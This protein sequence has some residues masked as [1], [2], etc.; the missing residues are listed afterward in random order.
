M[1]LETLYDEQN[2]QE[3]LAAV[4]SRFCP[5]CGTAIVQNTR[6]RKKVFCSESCRLKWNHKNPKPQN[7]KGARTAICPVC[8]RSFLA[9]H[10]N[11][12]KRKYCSHACANKGRTVERR[13]L[14][15]GQNTGTEAGCG[16]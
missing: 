3:F 15:D 14:F 1:E 5:E 16:A 6:G 12:Q 4:A 7:W 9:V 8:G 2:I 10:E 11:R 13:K